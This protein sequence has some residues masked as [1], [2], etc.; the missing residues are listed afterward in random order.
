MEVPVQI[1]FRGSEPTPRLREQIES[2]LQNLE[3][4]FGRIIA[5]RVVISAPSGRH[6]T[7]GLYDVGIHLTL[8][9]R[10]L[11][12][13]ERTPPLD[14]R[15]SDPS[16][17]IGDAFRRARRKLQD[18]ARRIDGRVKTH[19]ERTIGRVVRLNPGAG[20]GFILSEDEGEI[21]FHR[22][23]VLDGKFD[24]L[25]VGSKVA[26]VVEDGDKGPQASTVRTL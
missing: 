16:F 19:E 9:G 3:D 4:A 1:D 11:V 5:A 6:K 21:Y 18:E 23:S 8:P 10:H 22:N 24:S 15:F 2:K 17:A 26:F 13:V 20:F 7:G 25:S 12:E 14:E